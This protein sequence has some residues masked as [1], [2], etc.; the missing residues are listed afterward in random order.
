MG[1]KGNYTYLS[2]I[3]KDRVKR[4]NEA[5]MQRRKRKRLRKAEEEVED[6][7]EE[8]KEEEVFAEDDE[9]VVMAA[10]GTEDREEGEREEEEEEEEEDKEEEEKEEDKEE[11]EQEEEKEEEGALVEEEVLVVE[12]EGSQEIANGL[13]TAEHLDTLRSESDSSSSFVLVKFFP[14]QTELTQSDLHALLTC[15]RAPPLRA[16]VLD[17]RVELIYE[18][19]KMLDVLEF[20]KRQVSPFQKYELYYTGDFKV[21]NANGFI[22]HGGFSFVGVSSINMYW[23]PSKLFYVYMRYS[24]ADGVL[25]VHTN[26]LQKENELTH[27]AKTIVVPFI[28]HMRRLG[29]YEATAEPIM[30]TIVVEEAFSGEVSDSAFVMLMGLRN[31]MGE[32]NHDHHHDY[33]YVRN[34]CYRVAA[35]MRKKRCY[36]VTVNVD[37]TMTSVERSMFS[38]GWVDQQGPNSNGGNGI[39]MNWHSMDAVKSVYG[40]LYNEENVNV[41]TY[42]GP[43]AGAEILRLMQLCL[44]YGMMLTVIMYDVYCYTF[45][46]KNLRTYYKY[47][48][49]GNLGTMS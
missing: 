8:E 32:N 35:E 44:I 14:K 37:N 1:Q 24:V 46:M 41:W 25:F 33:T 29:A 2:N 28:D 17:I 49:T 48:P 7:M 13:I 10:I 39:D 45:F 16:S 23:K 34:L 19:W 27:S 11:E 30:I 9:G 43:A 47:F 21:V 36:S 6:E 31:S 20:R 26:R 42:M 22:A 5:Q 4:A 3:H 18:Y 15:F 40:H 12:D 38:K